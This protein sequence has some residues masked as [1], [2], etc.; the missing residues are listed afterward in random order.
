[1]SCRSRRLTEVLPDELRG[2]DG[3]SSVLYERTVQAFLHY[4]LPNLAQSLDDEDAARHI[5]NKMPDN[6][7]PDKRRMIE[8]LQETGRWSERKLI[9]EKCKSIVDGEQKKT[10]TKP[11][12]AAIPA[13]PLNFDD[14]LALQKVAF[15]QF[16]TQGIQSRIDLGHPGLGS[17]QSLLGA[18][19]QRGIPGGVGDPKNQIKF[20]DGFPCCR[21][22][23]TLHHRT[24]NR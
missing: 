12:F 5:V 4:I 17:E 9:L 20:C 18:Q 16:D 11:S 23:R 14:V 3:C 6:L 1:M 19:K 7:A 15:V 22:P 13:Y 21:S 8:W 2:S 24:R 10:V